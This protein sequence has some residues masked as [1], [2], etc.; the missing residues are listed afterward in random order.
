[1]P[2]ALARTG[3]CEE[4]IRC[5]LTDEAAASNQT[6][7]VNI[8][9][10]KVDTNLNFVDRE[11]EVEKFWKDNKIF[12]KSMDSRKEGE[13]YTF[14]DGPPTAN[15]KPHIGH[16]LTRVIKDMIPRYRTMKGYMVP[17]KAGW[18]THGLP[19]ELEVEK[20]L[21]LDGK[22]QIE[23]YG[24]EPFIQQCKESV[25]KYKGMWEDFSSTVGFWADMEHPYVTY[26]NNFIESE[27]W[28]LKEIWEK[29]LLYKG[30]KIVPYCPRCGTPL[31]AQEVSQG[32]KTV[33]E[34][35]AIVRFKVV[36]EDAYF[37]AWTTTPWTLPS[38]V[39]LCVN[40]DEIYCKVKAADGYTYYMAEALLD[41]VLGKLAKDDE[42]AYE[43]LE[44]YK[45]TD[46]ERREYE[47]LFACTG[48]A[49]AK[50]RKKAHFVTC[51]N[52]VTMSD[53][54]GIVHIA[55]AFGEDDSRVGREYDLP[56]VQFVDGQGNMTKET[57]Y[58]GVF[59]KKA[60][61][62]VLTDL[63]KEGKLFDAPKFE[64]DYPHCWRCDTPLIYYA[65]ESW[66]IKMTAVKDDLIR[67][68]NTIN[69]IP[70]SI[71][72]GRFGD[73]LENVQDWGISRNRYWGTPLN[74][75]Q[76]ECGHME[77][78]GSRQDLYEKSGDERAKTIELH[79]PYIDDITM[80]CPDCGKTMHRVPEV[81]D[82]WFDSGAMPF[83]QHHYPFEN[84]DLFEQQ[85]PADFISEAVDQTR[86]W[87]YSLLAES[88]L[89]F[90]KAPYKNVIVLGHV[91]DE[92]GQ[93]MSKSKGN[94][95]DPFDALNKYGA[96]A[97]R[98]YFYI[99]SAPWL[100][101]RFHGKAVVEGQRKFMS[102]LWNTYAFFVLYANIDN[103]DATKYTLNYDKLPVMDK[104]L[105]SKLNTM[106]KTVDADL[107]SY[108]I[109]EAARA[110]QEFVDDM[111]NW[112]VRRSRER[113]WAKG[114]EQ[115]KINAYMTLYTAL[116][117]VAKAAAPMIPFMTED[118][119]QNLV[120]SIDADAPESIHLCDY[121]EVNEAWIDKDLEA[122]MEELLEIV[123]LGRACRNTAN[124]KNRQP[125]GTMYVKAEKAMDKF[126]TDI[127]AD[128]LNVKEVK[129]ADDVE[130]FISYSFKPQL[131]TV[132]P[133]YGKLL[134]GIRTALSE[135]DGTAAMKELR[136]NGVLV[137]D[138]AG[139]RVE[140]AEEDLL[141]ET[142]QSEGYVTETDGETSVVLDTNLT[143]ELIQEGFVREIISKIQT[144][145]KEAG[146][147]VMDKIIVYAKDNDKIMDIMKA[148]QD[149]IKREVLAENIILGEA[150][151]YTKEWNINK[152]AVTL[153]V[154]KVQEEN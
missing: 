123:V 39:A 142:A 46:L 137:L 33:K 91:Q 139:N 93:K 105:L 83:A 69:W 107:D 136:D 9:Y 32:Y 26:D 125:I 72:K 109:P 96:D 84:K 103:F 24:M 80:K 75:W 116:V 111:S 71:G 138:I 8:V 79:R 58:A 11:K 131:R 37:L 95:V 113:F 23:E 88:T 148:N 40:P 89:L 151:G 92:N 44:K 4:T 129:F 36:G 85:F 19:V 153:G 49:A 127:I 17:R 53:G 14:Y 18:D 68:N 35:S 99:N 94:A 141:I 61:P 64:H 2:E 50:Q 15:G 100:P 62:M 134:N 60:D 150:E 20:K 25:W 10:R 135:I 98:W 27:W 7:E 43:I 87:F 128:E 114:M 119:Y 104:W 118:I 51:D 57:P 73:W 34:R 120:R 13:T 47:P 124:I 117:T 66:F 149:E 97:I 122:N 90:N 126:Y 67:N 1:M 16:V 52:Y 140:L 56:F 108:K 146:F 147:E 48:E 152:E 22:E 45:G 106:V 74:I 29:G 63:D 144:M 55:P 121:P 54:T 3:I 41:K 133:K 110:L 115:D 154:S 102:T 70:E 78:V 28:A 38:N 130:S 143:P 31:S 76:C 86:G 101:N 12:E 6:Q 81:I 65:R 42:P 82:C 145:R 77:S 132:G 59:V 30:F 112:Y 5:G 21:G